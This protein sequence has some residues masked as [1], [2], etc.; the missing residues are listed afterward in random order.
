M[1]PF[2]A[3]GATIAAINGRNSAMAAAN[4]TKNSTMEATMLEAE[5]VFIMS[6][7]YILE[8]TD[9][10][11]GKEVMAL[12]YSEETVYE[13]VPKLF[14]GVKRIPSVV[15][16]KNKVPINEAIKEKLP[17]G[18]VVH[19]VTFDWYNEQVDVVYTIK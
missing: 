6:I 13:E 4:I 12:T 14:G 3:G 16:K 1:I 18:A 10:N 19:G 7:P 8:K 17:E 9:Q 11:P 5:K 2:Y 15:Q